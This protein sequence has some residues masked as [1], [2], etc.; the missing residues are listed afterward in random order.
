MSQDNTCPVA[1]VT[2]A[3][4][5]IGSTV[6]TRLVEAGYSVM[7]LGRDQTKLDEMCAN[8]H[9]TKAGWEG[10][11]PP[12]YPMTATHVDNHMA[13]TAV[14]VQKAYQ[15]M[16]ERI[17]LLV[18]CHGESPKPMKVLDLDYEE[19]LR[20][21]MGD[22]WHSVEACQM[23]LPYMR[24]NVGSIV[25]LSSFHVTGTYPGRA[26]YNMAKHAIVGLTQSLC[27]DYA[28]YGININCIA[29]GQVD[30]PR[31][32]GF[33]GRAFEDDG[34]DLMKLWKARAP[35][36]KI[37]QEDDIAQTVIW[38]AKTKAV[39]GQTIVIDHGVTASNYYEAF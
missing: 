21:M 11:R 31:S 37:V 16:G 15:D 13:D 39:N 28:K 6:A 19:W 12:P 14:A 18:C 7:G 34:K 35:A 1:I 36:G 2:G 26:A 33:V 3:T 10:F 4:G 27:C 8:L 22:V 29:P 23:V 17:D 5:G 30:G 20:M 32:Q 9:F 38:L 24:D 25:L